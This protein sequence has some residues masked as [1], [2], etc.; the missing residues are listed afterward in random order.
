M[1]R[2]RYERLFGIMAAMAA[3][4]PAAVFRLYADF[5]GHVGAAMRRELR[6]LGV[7]RLAP[8][9]LDGMVM[10]Q[11]GWSW[12]TPSMTTPPGSTKH[13]ALSPLPATG[14]GCTDE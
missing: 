1:D 10:S 7:D 9:A 12:L 11:P 6:R 13:T 3:G 4:D 5:G 8:E 14:C 2:E